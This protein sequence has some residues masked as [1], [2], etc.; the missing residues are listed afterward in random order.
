M[1]SPAL[2]L[3][4]V[5]YFRSLILPIIGWPVQIRFAGILGLVAFLWIMYRADRLNPS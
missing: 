1:K 4:S 5:I 2:S 3:L